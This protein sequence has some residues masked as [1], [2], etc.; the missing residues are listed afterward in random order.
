[1]NVF[2]II[3]S[4]NGMSW[5]Q[6]CL[7]SCGDALI[8]VVDNSSTDGTV[9][10]IKEKYPRVLLLEQEKNLGFGKANNLGIKHAL[11]Q[12][13]DYVLLLNQDAYLTKGTLDNLIDVY[14]R[15]P[16]YGILSP[17]HLN[18]NGTKLDFNF[19]NYISVNKQLIY[20]GLLKEFKDEIYKVPFVNAAAWLLPKKTIQE[21]GGFDPIFYHY[22]EDNNYCQRV[23]YHNFKIGVVPDTFILHDRESR[24]IKKIVSINE[25]LKLRE[26]FLK[27]KWAD[28][29]ISVDGEI[30]K[31]RRA[32]KK[33]LLKSVIR[34]KF[35]NVSNIISELKLINTIENEIL[36]S[37]RINKEKGQ[38]YI[39]NE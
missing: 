13:A 19:S 33:N 21:I 1:M 32:L 18:G 6:K 8:I 25:K 14:R 10:F 37:R 28:L 4:Y 38:H 36:E 15:H 27:I 23:L 7:D 17:I 9:A 3:V 30:N 31:N 2:I 16:D 11:Q 35:Q 5:I 26:R 29:N 12:G 22:A 34:L 24:K 20:D 39:E